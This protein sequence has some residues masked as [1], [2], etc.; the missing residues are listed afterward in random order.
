MLRKINITLC[1]LVLMATWS[2]I[3]AQNIGPL[4]ADSL[5]RELSR[6]SHDTSRIL[7]MAQLAEAYRG[8]KNDSTLVYATEALEQSRRI[9]YAVGESKA[10][11]S[12]CHYFWNRGNLPAALDAGLRALRIARENKLRYDQAFAMIRVGNVYH[13]MDDSQEALRYYRETR[14]LVEH[15]PDSFF[16]AV[17]LW[18]S[19]DVYAKMNYPDSALS[20]ALKAYDTAAKMNNA[21]IL[22]QLPRVLGNIYAAMGDDKQALDY[23]R[24]S[25]DRSVKRGEF[26][27]VASAY[28]SMSRYHRGLGHVD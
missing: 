28:L 25:I 24:Q 20:L 27:S 7:I 6:A 12:I 3:S 16:Y 5:H 8:E 13:A 15:S 17:T 1:I 11:S 9:R 22:S 23:Y 10:L 2:S 21:L 19:A 4:Q 14:K 18:L 26:N